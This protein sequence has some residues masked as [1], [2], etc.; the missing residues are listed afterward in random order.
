MIPRQ[1]LVWNTI[2]KLT[3]Q[4]E[5]SKFPISLSLATHCSILNRLTKSVQMVWIKE[6]YLPSPGLHFQ[7]SKKRTN[8]QKIN[9]FLYPSDQGIFFCPQ[10]LEGGTNTFQKGVMLC[11]SSLKCYIVT[12]QLILSQFPF[13][14]KSLF[15]RAKQ[16]HHLSFRAEQFCLQ[17]RSAASQLHIHNRVSLCQEP[18]LLGLPGG[19]EIRFIFILII[20]SRQFLDHNLCS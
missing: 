20:F 18:L 13:S 14:R 5:M 9:A 16:G 19:K 8:I 7:F 6:N 17:H 3:K 2:F 11:S 1:L 4:R 10:S 15:F 12:M